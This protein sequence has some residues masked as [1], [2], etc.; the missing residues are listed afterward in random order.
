VK[1]AAATAFSTALPTA[2]CVIG[3]GAGGQAIFGGLSFSGGKVDKNCA[4]LETAR[5][6]GIF[7]ADVA[8]CKV[9]ITTKYAKVASITMADCLTRRPVPPVVVVPP[10]PPAPIQVVVP[11]PVVQVVPPAPVPESRA[12]IT[13]LRS[14]GSCNIYAGVTNVCKRIADDAIVALQQD[15]AAGLTLRGPHQGAA[16]LTYFRQRGVSSA[17]VAMKFDD[18]QNWVLS[19]DL[20]TVKQ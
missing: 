1:P 15:P 7:G 12:T 20:F 9:M 2:P 17:R 11:A 3:Y 16:I 4:A 19:F 18:E 8:Y 6:F 10:P 14:L 5:S 13:E